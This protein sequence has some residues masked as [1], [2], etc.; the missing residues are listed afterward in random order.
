MILQGADNATLKQE[1]EKKATPAQA[2][3][4][5]AE[6][7]KRIAV[8][9]NFDKVQQVG[10]A[11]RRLNDLF[12]ISIEM[13]EAKTALAT[14]RELNKLM[15]LYEAPPPGE[16]S[17]APASTEA[18]QELQT[19]RDHLA[20]LNLANQGAPVSELARLAAAKIRQYG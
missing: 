7:G 19:T 4:A 18:E 1:L 11:I 17:T 13:G 9:A 14:Q 8:A 6:A 15:R 16:D 3:K 2:K 10:V 20:P 5:I 12:A